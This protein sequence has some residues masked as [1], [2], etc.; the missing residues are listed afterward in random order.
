MA[1]L[2]H[3]CSGYETL[4]YVNCAIGR[5]G[6]SETHE[7]IGFYSD[8]KKSSHDIVNTN[9]PQI[10]RRYKKFGFALPIVLNTDNPRDTQRLVR[11]FV[12]PQKNAKQL[13]LSSNSNS[14]D[15]GN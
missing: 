3:W 12:S 5:L 15:A 14:V 8:V 6:N 1:T 4:D 10:Y 2:I 11:L 13:Y 9:Y 7:I